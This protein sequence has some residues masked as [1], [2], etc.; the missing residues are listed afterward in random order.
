MS[1]SLIRDE[2]G[3]VLSPAIS[4]DRFG[5]LPLFL[6]FILGMSVSFVIRMIRLARWVLYKSEAAEK[7]VFALISLHNTAYSFRSPSV[8]L[9]Y[10]L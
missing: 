9:S 1:E 8:P 2:S 3:L 5:R 7:A 6:V 10:R 4:V